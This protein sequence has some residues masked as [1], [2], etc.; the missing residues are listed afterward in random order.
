[1]AHTRSL[2]AK[3]TLR[4]RFV[5]LDCADVFSSRDPPGRRR[6]FQFRGSILTDG[7]GLSVI[8]TD[9]DTRASGPRRNRTRDNLIDEQFTYI[10]EA[11]R[12][13]RLPMENCVLIDPGKRDRLFMMHEDSTTRNKNFRRFTLNDL[14]RRTARRDFRRI[15][16]AFLRRNPAVGR[17]QDILSRFNPAKTFP[18]EFDRVVQGRN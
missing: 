10:D 9:R 4:R 18:E 14:K 6:R 12:E 13:G 11:H 3:Q 1:M 8:K 2:V 15:H 7:I 17:A 16:L 5:D